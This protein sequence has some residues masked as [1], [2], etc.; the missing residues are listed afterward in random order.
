MA[1]AITKFKIFNASNKFVGALKHAEDAAALVGVL[2]DG[3]TIRTGPAKR[4][5]VWTE[6][7]ETQS[8]AESYD[9]VYE[10]VTTREREQLRAAHAKRDALLG[11][12]TLDAAQ[13]T[14]IELFA[15]WAGFQWKLVLATDWLRAGSRYADAHPV[16]W[17]VLYCM[18]NTHGPR[19]LASYTDSGAA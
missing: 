19:W 16:G 15:E 10:V 6:G 5:T 18:R 1:H 14:A 13:A 9:H 11:R 17:G 4:D 8:A 3:Y 2:G 12:K 7:A